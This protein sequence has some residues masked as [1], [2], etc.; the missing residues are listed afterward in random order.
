VRLAVASLACLAACRSDLEAVDGVFY[1]GDGRSVHCGVN[2][3][4][5]ANNDIA[6]IDTALD[7]AAARDEVVELYAHSPGVTVPMSRLR[8]VLEGARTRGLRFVTYRDFA[9]HTATGPGIALSFDDHAVVDWLAARETFAEF[10]ARV[11]FFVS[12]YPAMNAQQHAGLRTLAD[13]GHAIEAH[14]VQHLRAPLYVEE[15][16]VTAYL[17]DE[18]LPGIDAMER[19]GFPITSFAYPFGARTDETDRALLRHVQVLRSVAFSFSGLIHS[20]CPH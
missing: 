18:V 1:D 17:D 4:S 9:E 15:H 19:D 10:G 14:G 20:P 13:D 3:D 7:R 2:I 6:S 12:R 11:T 8:H 16:G 5:V